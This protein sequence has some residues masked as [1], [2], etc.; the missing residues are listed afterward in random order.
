MWLVEFAQDLFYRIL[1]LDMHFR[2]YLTRGEFHHR[3]RKHFASFY[4]NALV[5][6]YMKEKTIQAMGVFMDN[7]IA[8]L[9]DVFKVTPYDNDCSFVH[10]M[11]NLDHVSF[12]DSSYPLDPI[13]VDGT[14]LTW[15]VAEDVLY[16]SNIY[17]HMNDGEL[18]EPVR[19]KYAATWALIRSRHTKLLDV[20]VAADFDPNAISKSS[21]WEHAVARARDPDYEPP[22]T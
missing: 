16:L 7:R 14:D 1:H 5:D 2:A 11:Q 6:C 4:G 12:N 3:E 8:P 18:P 19:N 15:F 20:L 22:E 9:S 17:R 13:L 10:V 21:D